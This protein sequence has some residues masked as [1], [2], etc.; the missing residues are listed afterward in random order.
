MHI[1]EA[2]QTLGSRISWLADAMTNDLKEALGGVPNAELLIDP[3][4]RVAARRAWSDPAA[5]RQD[6][7]ALLGPVD[8]PTLIEELDMQPEAPTPTLA[9]GV[10]PRVKAPG[11]MRALRIEPAV[12]EA[13][14]PFYVKLRAEADVDFLERGDGKLYLGFHLDPLYRVHWNN[15]AKPLQ[16]ELTVP[17]RVQVSPIKGSAPRVERAVDADPREFLLDLRSREPGAVLQLAVRYFACDDANTFCVPV[18]QSY[19]VHL[20]PDPHGGSVFARTRPD[21]RTAKLKK[22]H[23]PAMRWDFDGDGQLTLDE[24]PEHLKR[25]FARFDADGNGALDIGEITAMSESMGNRARK[26]RRTLARDP[27]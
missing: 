4:G 20:E 13:K 3:D 6:L 14:H 18:R 22:L 8:P 17:E 7:A 11:F 21:S 12:E 16:F 15:L 25:R 23:I 10:V 24:A 5:L 27:E 1:A 2:Q 26:S 19:A 9:K